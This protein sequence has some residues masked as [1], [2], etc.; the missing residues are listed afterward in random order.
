M[1]LTSWITGF[2]KVEYFQNELRDGIIIIIIII[3]IVVVVVVVV[4]IGMLLCGYMSIE[5]TYSI[6][7][8][9]EPLKCYLL[10]RLIAF[11]FEMSCSFN[12]AI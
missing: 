2:L 12:I 9:H 10:Q 4:V 11:E 8:C 3:I 7:T 5:E 1:L 6:R